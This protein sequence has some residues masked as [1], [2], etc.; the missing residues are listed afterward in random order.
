[1][2]DTY[3]DHT[4]FDGSTYAS[5]GVT[6]ASP[7]KELYIAPGSLFWNRTNSLS[8]FRFPFDPADGDDIDTLDINLTAQGHRPCVAT[9]FTMVDLY[10]TENKY[11][12]FLDS[13]GVMIDQTS[14][15]APAPYVF[16][17]IISV[18]RPI[19]RIEI[20]E[21]TQSDG[22]DV[23]YDDFICVRAA[24]TFVPTGTMI[25]PRLWHTATLLNDG[26]VLIAG[27]ENNSAGR[28]N[29]VSS[30]ELYNPESGSFVPT[31]S[32][33]TARGLHTAT[34]LPN[35]KVLITGGRTADGRQLLSSAELYDPDTHTFTATGDMTVARDSHTATLL[36]NGRVLIVGGWQ[37]SPPSYALASAELYDPS[38]GKFTAT[39]NMTKGWFGPTAA[40]LP[41][42]KVLITSAYQGDGAGLN[43]ELYDPFTGTFINKSTRSCCSF[44][45][46][47]S[48]LLPNGTVLIAGGGDADNGLIQASAGIY[49]PI[50]GT[51]AS[52]GNMTT[53][54]YLH[55]ATV[56]FDRT[57]L[58]TGF[59]ENAELYDSSTGSFSYVSNMIRP[60]HAHTATLLNNGTVLF[61]GGLT[62][63]FLFTASAELYVP[64]VSVP[65]SVVADLRF[66]RSMV[67]V[68]GSY[69]L[70]VSGSSLTS[71]TFF[72]VRF[73][74]PGS[75][76]SDVVLNW[77]R[78]LTATH[79]VP[80]GTASGIWTITGVRAHQLETDHTGNFVSVTATID[81]TR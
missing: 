6:F 73:T 61:A 21:G 62:S 8:V 60:R 77:Q 74:A 52:A 3:L 15:P 72:D 41:D 33:T 67:T 42:G 27:G 45:W 17:G 7:G 35:G 66:D 59:F 2:T 22:D 20:V 44:Y 64:Y 13:N 34:L 70:N 69:S 1:V 56:L 76:T 48:S 11:V 38:T 47:T 30:A 19:A 36:N 29:A 55:T 57:V 18:D 16:L 80:A 81:V 37:P 39:S 49:D 25:T 79:S 24:G 63:S 5:V 32:M 4:K 28:Q 68:G 40:L 12:R 46:H 43:A 31:G 58:I 65:A 14:F 53:S 9:G 23:N 26:Q 75:R 50:T 78:G 51:F 71:Q 54:R 10:T